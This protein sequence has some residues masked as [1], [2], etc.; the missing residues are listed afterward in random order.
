MILIKLL[1]KIVLTIL[2]VL[3]YSVTVFIMIPLLILWCVEI[4]YPLNWWSKGINYLQN[5]YEKI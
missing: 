1:V 2:I 3:Q 5:E 4:K